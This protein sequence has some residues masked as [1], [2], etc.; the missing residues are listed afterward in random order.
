MLEGILPAKRDYGGF[1]RWAQKLAHVGRRLHT[2]LGGGAPAMPPIRAPRPAPP[3]C[4]V[5]SR[6]Y[7]RSRSPHPR[8]ILGTDHPSNQQKRLAAGEAAD[9]VAPPS[10]GTIAR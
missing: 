1:W 7:R 9:Q 8:S 3:F 5:T 6:T 2:F 10:I 4:V